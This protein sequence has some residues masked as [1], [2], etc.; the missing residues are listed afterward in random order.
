M[1]F[2][3]FPCP[4]QYLDGVQK[5]SKNKQY[6]PILFRANKMYPELNLPSDSMEI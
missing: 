2:G 4:L 1:I 6:L 3:F 5:R